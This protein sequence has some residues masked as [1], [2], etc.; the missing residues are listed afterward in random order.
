MEIAARSP[1][2]RHAVSS[3]GLAALA[4]SATVLTGFASLEDDL[5][6]EVSTLEAPAWT[7]S[8]RNLTVVGS[9]DADEVARAVAPLA[10]ALAY[11]TSSGARVT[12]Y[13][14]FSGGVVTEVDAYG[15][16]T[17]GNQC[18]MHA[19][20]KL[21][22]PVLDELDVMIPIDFVPAAP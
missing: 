15:T 16:D 20:D 7:A 4:V 8:I 2:A 21:A 1:A 6:L 22:V 14:H 9:P 11:C 19:I 5:E 3:L 10:T 18:A 12:I 13:A 17:G